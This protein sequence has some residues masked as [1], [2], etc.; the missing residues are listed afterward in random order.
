MTEENAKN[1]P[2]NFVLV[3]DE[4]AKNS[5]WGGKSHR[6]Q[7][8]LEREFEDFRRAREDSDGPRK[9]SWG[10]NRAQDD[11]AGV[12]EI[13]DFMRERGVLGCDVVEPYAKSIPGRLAE[14]R[15]RRKVKLDDPVPF[16]FEK[17]E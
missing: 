5:P 13:L 7:T 15:A 12:D 8:L 11:M 17:S 16:P 4:R 14:R 10:Q 9:G 6:A 2:P 1:E 3:E